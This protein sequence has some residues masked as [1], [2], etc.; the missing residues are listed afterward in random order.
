MTFPDEDREARDRSSEAIEG[1]AAA[2]MSSNATML[3]LVHEVRAETEARDKKIDLLERNHRQMQWLV[4]AVCCATVLM[5]TLGVVNAVNLA[6]TRSQQDQVKDINHT[7]L[8]CVNSTGSCGQINASNQ[9]KI[10]D[11]VKKYELIGFYCIRN[12]S[13]ASDPR[14][15]NFLKCMNK[16]YPGGPQLEGRWP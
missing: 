15:E 3:A 11:E 5:L 16:L 7:L 13:A 14:G 6:S 4:V 9:Q 1:L 2:N 12:N 8:D 10:V